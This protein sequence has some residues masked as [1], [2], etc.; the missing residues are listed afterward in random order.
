MSHC[1][2]DEGDVTRSGAGTVW[3]SVDN[4]FDAPSSLAGLSEIFAFFAGD[5]IAFPSDR[6]NSVPTSDSCTT[7]LPEAPTTPP[8]LTCD[9]TSPLPFPTNSPVLPDPPDLRDTGDLLLRAPGRTTVVPH[10][11]SAS[12]RG[13]D[14]FR[15]ECLPT[16]VEG[17]AG[18]AES[19]DGRGIVVDCEADAA[20]T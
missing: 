14:F 7:I 10:S 2:L 17:S 4:D 18:G 6:G 15:A 8:S 11:A 1:G 12:R 19:A 9:P 3:S 5:S 13:T 16:A 20:D